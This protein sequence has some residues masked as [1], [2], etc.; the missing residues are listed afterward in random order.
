MR[1]SR[2]LSGLVAVAA[3]VVSL[4]SYAVPV[5]A[6][7]CGP[8]ICYQYWQS[9]AVN[10]EGW[11]YF[12]DPLLA[13]DNLIFTPSNFKAD[14]DV[15]DLSIPGPTVVHTFNFLHVYSTN[16]Q[17]IQ[18]MTVS[19]GGDYELD[20][21][22]G[23]VSNNMR[24]QFVDAVDNPGGVV[25]GTPESS[26]TNFSTGQ[27]TGAA[28]ATNFGPFKDWSVAGTVTP[29]ATFTDLVTDMTFQIQNTLK[30]CSSATSTPQCNAGTGPD[31]AFI[32]KK[33]NIV[34]TAT[35]VIPVPAAVW[36]FGSGLGLLGVLRRRS[37]V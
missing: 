32:Q 13:G 8:T 27:I 7:L 35:T 6:T 15:V 28:N 10:N 31:Y 18:S 11:A 12:G 2:V 16:G 22:T 24:L 34:V 21:G 30:A 14:S 23:Y 5:L 1:G 33:L 25:W 19:E 36:L 3:A 20:Y 37:V 17:E 9:D 4:P 29:A 26:A